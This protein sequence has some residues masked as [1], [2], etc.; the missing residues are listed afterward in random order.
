MTA[1]A[2]GL[3]VIVFTG[4]AGGRL[5]EIADITFN[6]PETRTFK[7]QEMHLPLYHQLCLAVENELFD[8]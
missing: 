3:K 5:K 1:K 7:V 2:L 6:V 4:E 8:E